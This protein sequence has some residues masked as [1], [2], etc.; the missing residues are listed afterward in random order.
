MK[1]F[2]TI[3][4]GVLIFTSFNALQAQNE[5]KKW[6]ISMGANGV[7]MRPSAGLFE[8]SFSN[9]FDI[10]GQWNFMP[11]LSYITVSRHLKGNLSVGLTASVNTIRKSVEHNDITGKYF[12]ENPGDLS[13]FAFDLN[14]KYSFQNAIDSNI[15]DPYAYVGF[16]GTGLKGH[17]KTL[18]GNYGIGLNAWILD[19]LAL[20][21][22][23][24]FR[25]QTG[26]IKNH[27]QHLIGLTFAFGKKDSDK[28]G[29]ADEVD[30][31][32]T[33]RGL[34]EFNGCPDTDAD[35]IQDSEDDC[36]EVA[37]LAD[38]KGCPDSDGD[39]VADKDDNCPKV[40]GLVD[41]KGCPDADKDGVADKDDK[42]VDVA[43]PKENDGCPWPDTDGDG[44]VDKDDK[45]P[46][47]VG[48]V[49][50]SGCPEVTEEVIKKLNNF[51]LKAVLF[52]TGKTSLSDKA[53]SILDEMAK[54]MIEYGNDRFEIGG[55]TDSQGS[56]TSNQIL[57]EKRAE[58]IKQYLVDAGVDP[59][60]LTAKGYGEYSPIANNRTRSGRAKNRRVEI[61]HLK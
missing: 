28:D 47:V 59:N 6:A 39:G 16:G 42:C 35:G 54:L 12:V 26:S 18:S 58:S 57:S 53:S 55:H 61:I 48:A 10:S 37:G 15:F 4:L 29:V 20:T 46:D 38:L 49:D 34:K 24:G 25:Q 23:T 36:P 14:A 30:T 11:P 41:L 50:N 3:L 33:V 2:R 51:L 1:T 21:I 27:T 43:G 60:N 19:G 17:S 44:T 7:N 32:P 56:E 31:C 9:Y 22:Q 45:C 13:F 40:A 52:E 8:D 5:S